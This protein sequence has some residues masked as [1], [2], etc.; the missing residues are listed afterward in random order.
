MRYSLVAE[1]KNSW[2]WFSVHV[3]VIIAVLPELYA[4]VEVFQGFLS[5]RGFQHLTAVLGVLSLIATLHKKSGETVK[6][7]TSSRKKK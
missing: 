1:W 2:K 4:N 3:G 5:E 6:P 7:P